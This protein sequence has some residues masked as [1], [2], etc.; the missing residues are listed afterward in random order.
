MPPRK[1]LLPQ[2]RSRI[3]ELYSAGYGYKRIHKIYR[4]I[5]LSTIRYTI[6]ELWLPSIFRLKTSSRSIPEHRPH[7]PPSF[8]G[9]EEPPVRVVVTEA[10]WLS[11]L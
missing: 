10:A 2:M 6:Q 8:G 1:E 4:D 9:A 7:N 3:C 11:L 5:P